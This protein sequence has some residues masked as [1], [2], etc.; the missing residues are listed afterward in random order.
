MAGARPVDPVGTLERLV[1][2]SKLEK[3]D[4][5]LFRSRK[6]VSAIEVDGVG[7]VR[8]STFLLVDL[9]LIPPVSGTGYKFD[10]GQLLKIQ[11]LLNEALNHENNSWQG[12]LEPCRRELIWIPTTFKADTENPHAQFSAEFSYQKQTEEEKK[13]N[14]TEDNATR[15]N[16]YAAAVA[17]GLFKMAK[18]KNKKTPWFEAGIARLEIMVS[19]YLETRREAAIREAQKKL[20]EANAAALALATEA[21]TVADRLAAEA[22]VAAT[23]VLEARAAVDRAA[24]LT[25]AEQVAAEATYQAA[26]IR[27][28]E[29]QAQATQA[30]A[31]AIKAARFAVMTPAE[32]AA[33]EAEDARLAAMSPAERA[34]AEAEATRL[35][36][37][38]VAREAKRVADTAEASRGAALAARLACLSPEERAAEYYARD[39][40]KLKTAIV[41]KDKLT[42]A[43]IIIQYVTQRMSITA[44]SA[45]TR[46]NLDRSIRKEMTSTESNVAA[47]VL[48]DDTRDYIINRLIEQLVDLSVHQKNLLVEE[49]KKEWEAFRNKVRT[50]AFYQYDQLIKAKAGSAVKTPFAGPGESKAVAGTDD[51]IGADLHVSTASETGA[52]TA[53]EG[54]V[55]ATTRETAA[56][57]STG[58]MKDLMVKSKMIDIM[59]NVSRIVSETL[60]KAS[61][62][63][64]PESIDLLETLRKEIPLWKHIESHYAVCVLVV[65]RERLLKAGIEPSIVDQCMRDIKAIG[66]IE[67]IERRRDLQGTVEAPKASRDAARPTPAAGPTSAAGPIPAAGPTPA[68]GPIPV[69]GVPIEGGHTVGALQIGNRYRSCPSRR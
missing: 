54:S 37:E 22:Q 33:V 61:G 68:A 24:R 19:Q 9:G 1:T 57:S 28:T 2:G 12:I 43:Q 6:P 4:E 55:E 32:R 69:A 49:F 3:Y 14:S 21:R 63:L 60:S 64:S 67:G 38:Q 26:K 46:G 11:I 8:V 51:A 35:A 39:L 25:P 23:H 16:A 66:G 45:R 44:I 62:T 30:E 42:V 29:L 31:R 20:A 13:T 17:N 53:G 40:D 27:A 34:A 48:N 50:A 59:T 58:A 47:I 7:Y 10:E 41:S 36:A 5:A 15:V 52:V 56:T 18:A 65:C